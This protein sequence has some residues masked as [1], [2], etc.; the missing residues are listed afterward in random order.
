MWI[1]LATGTTFAQDLAFAHDI[2]DFYIYAIKV[3]ISC[4]SAAFMAN[5][6]PFAVPNRLIRNTDYSAIQHSAYRHVSRP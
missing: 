6:Q 1:D 4:F 5:G 2:S 3:R